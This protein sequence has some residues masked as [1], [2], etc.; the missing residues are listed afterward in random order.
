MSD[1][2]QQDSGSPA[3]NAT[4]LFPILYGTRIQAKAV[5]EF[6][7]AQLQSLAQ[8]QNPIRRRIVN[9]SAHEIDF[10]AHMRKNLV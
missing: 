9:D 7:S 5:R 8:S 6:F 1:D 2:G 4:T 3:R 10:A